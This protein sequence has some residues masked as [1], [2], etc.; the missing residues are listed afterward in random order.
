LTFPLTKYLYNHADAIVVYGSHVRRYL[1]S[2]GVRQECIFEAWHA[3]DNSKYNRPVSESELSALRRKLGLGAFRVVLFV[4]RLEPEKG[5]S[6]L[7]QAIG[8]LNPENTILLFVGAG[9][10][11]SALELECAHHKILAVFAGYVPTDELYPYY[12]LANVFVLPSVT[13]RSSK[14][15]WG[16]VV[17]EAFNQGVPVVASDAVGAA[18][19]GLVQNDVTGFIVPERDVEALA[20]A[21][22]LLLTDDSLRIRMGDAAFQAIASWDN[23]RMVQG[24]RAAIRYACARHGIRYSE[25]E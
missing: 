9:Q 20:R 14:E 10:E 16:L 21:I 1:I 19:G 25:S 5:L 8:K 22:N 3:L 13:T 17:N 2:L 11:R 12:A 6:F 7:V 24:F 23:E 4:G 15:T 18:A